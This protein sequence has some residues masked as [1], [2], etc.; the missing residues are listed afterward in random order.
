MT[1]IAACRT[2]GTEPLENARFCHGCGSPVK[3]GDTRAEYKQVTVLFADV[4]HSMDIAAAVGTERLREVMADLADRCAA[5]VERYGGTVDKFTGDGI[6]AVFGAPVALEDHAICACLAALGVQEETKRL[7]VD[8]HARDGVDLQLRVGLNSGQVIAGEIGSGALGYTA[9]GE[10]VGM[11]QRMESV[12]PPGGVMLSASTA[13]LVDGAATLGESELVQIKGADEGVPARRLLG[14]GDQHRA[15]G[16]AESNLVG[17]RWEMSAV[18][19]LLDRAVDGHGVVV[20]V[21]GSPGI[22]KSR[23]VRE[24]AAMA[25]ARGVDVFTAFCDSHTSQ[26]P[27]HA[28]ARLLRAATGVEGLDGQAARDRVRD[29]VPDADPEDLLLL[30][31]LLSIAD[32]NVPLPAIDPDARRRRLTALLNA[33]SLA[34]ETPAVYVVEDAHW[35]DEVSESMIADFLTVIP[36]TPSLVL[37]TYRPE[38]EGALARVHGAQIIALAPLSDS[39][40]AALVSELLGPDPSNGALGKTIAERAAG[41]PFFAEEIVWDLAER[42]VLQGQTGAYVSTADVSEAKVPAT[43]QATIAARIDRLDPNAKRT[44]S[45]AAVIGSRFDLDLLTVL[46]IEP[47][48]ADLVA[49]QF[50]DQVRFTRQHEYVFHHPLIRAVAYESQLK[51]DRTELHRRA[52]A[53]IEQRSAG[54]LDENAA[55][56]AEHLQAAGDLHAA[57]S[58]HMRA[59]AWAATRDIVAAWASWERARQVADALPADDAHRTAMRIAARAWLCGNAFRVHAD[60]SDGLFEELRELCTAAGDKPSLANGMGGLMMEHMRHG[61]VREASRLA[62]ETMA[63]VESIGKP[64]LTVGLSL[65]AISIKLQTGEMSE[66]LRWSQTVI[67]LA[68][69]DPTKGNIVF[70]SPLAMALAS[71]GTALWALGRAGWRDDYDRALAMAREADPMS[72]AIVNTYTYG[73]AIADGVLLADDAALRDIEK[74]LESTE[75]SSEDFALGFARWALGMA[76]V[77]R[78]SPAER[79]RG[80]AV[81][82]QVRDMCL[83]GR[84]Y[85]FSLAAVDVYTARELARCGDRDGAIPQICAAIDDLFHAGQHSYGIPATGFLVETLL[86]RGANGDVIDAE[87][88]IERLAAVPADE[89]LVIRD[90]WLL[91][92]RAL[93]ARAQGDDARYRDYRDRYRAMA[94]SLGF[95][96]HMK[97]ADVL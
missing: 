48:V 17:R 96:G 46:G 14:S 65:A 24:V 26:V 62:S 69:G 15:A 52:A 58:W 12:A 70:G 87:A 51:S 90:I 28:V 22:G 71:R 72:H 37:A 66:A 13:R 36:Q 80:L 34:R 54:S 75:R 88:A 57:F 43:L 45:G 78:E 74:A 84:F 82:E 79:E 55:L 6:M 41:N 50:I 67:E 56:I 64:T 33:A 35:I 95:D 4:V 7:A 83:E 76:L 94:T 40:T 77:H 27:F 2:C 32:P 60:I 21:V 3:D 91:R 81:L 1:A 61:R 68:D 31:D 86:E 11:A 73:F 53:A 25:A 39:E 18:E 30:H 29:R 49:A 20:D 38:Y 97:W 19:G 85:Q 93:L 42:G 59:G 47:V 23:L 44:L 9:V 92:L 5:V 63:L 8:V 89:G 16:R 10:Q